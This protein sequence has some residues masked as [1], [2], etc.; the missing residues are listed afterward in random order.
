MVVES[1][2]REPSPKNA[3]SRSRASPGIM[4]YQLR[5]GPSRYSHTRSTASLGK[6]NPF[7][8][9]AARRKS[10]SG[11]EAMR[12]N[13]RRPG[14]H[15]F[16]DSKDQEA[17]SRRKWRRNKTIIFIIQAKHS[18]SSSSSSS[19]GKQ[20]LLAFCQHGNACVVAVAASAACLVD[21]ANRKQN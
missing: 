18:S 17:L 4:S 8:A 7:R 5:G 6:F 3:S 1:K 12:A 11:A 15:F 10:G 9:S 19:T 16:A 20:S 13:T 2:G 14:G 21:N